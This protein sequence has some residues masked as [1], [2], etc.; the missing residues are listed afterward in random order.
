M[1]LRIVNVL[2]SDGGL[3]AQKKLLNKAGFVIDLS[4]EK[5][6]RF[7]SEKDGFQSVGR[8]L[9]ALKAGVTFLGP[10]DYHHL[11]LHFL[12]KLKESPV[13]LLFDHHSDMMESPP[14]TISCGSWAALALAERRVKKCLVVGINP[15]D[16]GFLKLKARPEIAFFPKDIPHDSKVSGVL[17]ELARSPGPLYISIDKDV[18]L[19]GEAVTNWDQGS[20]TL[21]ELLDFLRVAGRAK[22]LAGADICGEWPALPVEMLHSQE[23]KKNIEVNQ[24]ANLKI[25]DALS[26]VM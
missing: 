19:S 14:G 13:L 18:L 7:C 10:G 23:D 25:L 11:S 15:K 4:S 9:R 5:G 3:A 24:T 2:K 6:I 17:R 22:P 21:E 12:A 26:E 1:A 8:K 20:M 16:E